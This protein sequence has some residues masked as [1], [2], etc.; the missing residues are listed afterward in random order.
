[1]L[2]ADTGLPW[3]V[4]SPNIP[5]PA[6][7]IAYVATV[8]LEATTAAEGRGT[9]TP[10]QL[11]GAPFVTARAL[12]STLNG[13]MKNED[14]PLL[15]CFREAYFE[16]TFSKYNGSVVNGV[17]WIEQRCTSNFEAAVN[18]LVAIKS[19][20]SP[21]SAFV[22]DGSWFGHPGTTLIDEYAGT[23]QLREMIDNNVPV[24][25]IVKHFKPDEDLF[26]EMRKSSLLY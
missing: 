4:P 2:F 23:P 7:A 1:M 22:W 17:Q 3:V 12:A 5:T 15:N 24:E 11:F 14:Y 18:I 26:R 21:A 19:L 25:D 8:F 16:P 13:A 10:F 6:S 20:S 9:T